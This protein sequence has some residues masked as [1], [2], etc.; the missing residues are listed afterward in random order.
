MKTGKR[1]F[2]ISLMF[3]LTFSLISVFA[4]NENYVRSEDTYKGICKKITN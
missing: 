4:E 2:I 1:L 3:I